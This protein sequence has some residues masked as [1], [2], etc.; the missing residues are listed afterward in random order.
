VI[1]SLLKMEGA[2]PDLASDGHE[3]IARVAETEGPRYDLAL[4]DVEMPGIDGYETARRL[5]ELD[6]SLPL[7]GQTARA[8]AED[9]EQCLRAGMR[10]RV[11][12]PIEREDLVRQVLA[13][14]RRA[15]DAR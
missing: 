11:V 8:M 5:H 10:G 2:L 6:P 13:H 4:L 12:K 1:D 9:L 15:Q 3:A 7:L 14:A